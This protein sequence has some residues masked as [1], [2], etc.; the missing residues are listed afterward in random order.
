MII[1]GNL[2]KDKTERTRFIFW[3]GE[4]VGFISKPIPYQIA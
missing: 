3:L 2:Q 4:L 1:Y